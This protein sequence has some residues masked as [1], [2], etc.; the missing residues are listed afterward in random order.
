ML[1]AVKLNGPWQ[2]ELVERRP[3]CIVETIILAAAIFWDLNFELCPR[4]TLN[5]AKKLGLKTRNFSSALVKELIQSLW[6]S[7]TIKQLDAL[8]KKN[9]D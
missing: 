9:L 6:A 7:R 2:I 3:A 8:F 4:R 1:S 5:L